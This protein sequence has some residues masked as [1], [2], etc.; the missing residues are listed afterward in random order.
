MGV[1]IL[2]RS[3]KAGKKLTVV[4]PTTAKDVHFGDANYEDFVQHGDEERKEAYL[5]RHREN[6]NWKDP[7]TPGFWAR[8]LLWNKKTL[9]GSIDDLEA[10]FN[11]N[12]ILGGEELYDE[13]KL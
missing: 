6:E 4:D 1:Y 11:I 13:L 3:R 5:K 10:R 12:V 9:Q 2:L 7:S 8:W